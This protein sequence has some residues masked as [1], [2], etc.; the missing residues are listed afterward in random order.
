M[1]VLLKSDAVKVSKGREAKAAQKVRAREWG[2]GMWD[3]GCGMWDV[4]CGMRDAGMRGCGK[5]EW[6]R[7][8]F[9]QAAHS[10]AAH[11]QAA[12]KVRARVGEWVTYGVW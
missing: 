3:V 4:G 1:R 9:P 6:Y 12:E 8:L 7:S 2:C 5:S 10:Q 11:S